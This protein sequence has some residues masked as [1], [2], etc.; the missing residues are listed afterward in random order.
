MIVTEDMSQLPRTWYHGTTSLHI[1][2]FFR[3]GINIAGGRAKADFGRGF[4]LTSN[5]D[6]AYRWAKS[7]CKRESAEYPL[8]QLDPVIVECGVYTEAFRE[9]DYK[10]FSKTDIEWA[11]FILENRTIP[12]GPAYPL[13]NNRDSDVKKLPQIR[14]TME[15]VAYARTA[16]SYNS[17]YGPMA[18]GR[19]LRN[20]IERVKRGKMSPDQFLRQVTSKKY[21]FPISH[22]LSI[23]THAASHYVELRG[24]FNIAKGRWQH[25]VTSREA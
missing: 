2:S 5:W 16:H 12:V 17:V 4:Y 6:Q 3:H 14:E 10:M 25:P 21:K 13:K 8:E 20:C 7:A 19:D 11:E 22:Q 18:D 23:N 15:Q 9:L 24:V 1:N